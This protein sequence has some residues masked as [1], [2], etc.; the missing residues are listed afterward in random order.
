VLDFPTGDEQSLSK[1]AILRIQPIAFPSSMTRIV[2][3][4]AAVAT[5]LVSASCCCTGEAEAPKLKPLPQ[6]QEIPTQ[7]APAEVEYS[8]K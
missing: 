8:G 6:F 5:A 1:L 3:A 2:F 7:S 4:L